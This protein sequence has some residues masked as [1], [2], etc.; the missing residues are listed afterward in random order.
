[1]CKAML[2]IDEETKSTQ[3]K[4]RQY[5]SLKTR[6][7]IRVKKKN[8]L[9]ASFAF[10]SFVCAIPL[11]LAK[12]RGHEDLGDTVRIGVGS[13]TTVLEVTVALL[14]SLARDTN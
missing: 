7:R 4:W 6:L 14:S 9:V 12:D 11:Q 3:P 13:G 1:M 2:S 10:Y 5:P 8:T